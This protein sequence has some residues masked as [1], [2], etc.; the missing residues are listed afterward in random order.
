MVSEGA[1]EFRDNVSVLPII[2]NKGTMGWRNTNLGLS[3]VL[4]FEFNGGPVGEA[5]GDKFDFE[6]VFRSN[7]KED[8]S[9]NFWRDVVH[10]RRHD[11]C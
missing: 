8:D 6:I 11:G 4:P 10:G 7:I 5:F 9:Q 1:R 2:T 3:H